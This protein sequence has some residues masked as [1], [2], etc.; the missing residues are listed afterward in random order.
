MEVLSK[1]EFLRRYLRD[2]RKRK[3]EEQ[4]MKEEVIYGYYARRYRRPNPDIEEEE[5]I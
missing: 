1:K 5:V 2:R 4:R 3:E